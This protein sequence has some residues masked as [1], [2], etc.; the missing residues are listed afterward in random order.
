MTAKRFGR[1]SPEFV[2]GNPVV[3]AMRREHKQHSTQARLRHRR[4]NQPIQETFCES[5]IKD[6]EAAGKFIVW[7]AQ[8]AYDKLFPKPEVTKTSQAV[9]ELAMNNSELIKTE[10]LL[11]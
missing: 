11:A 6:I 8:Q 9:G 1:G 4:D 5:V 3:Q 7:A 10:K 2:E